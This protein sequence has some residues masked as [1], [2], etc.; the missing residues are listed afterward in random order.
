VWFT[1]DASG[2]ATCFSMTMKKITPNTFG[3]AIY[4]TTGPA[5]NTAFDPARVIATQVGTGTLTFADRNQGSFSYSVNAVVQTKNIA[6]VTFGD[7][8]TICN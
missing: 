7:P 1:Y 2:K 6:R 3:G 8:P 4:R 5:Y